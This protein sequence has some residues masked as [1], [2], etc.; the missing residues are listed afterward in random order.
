VKTYRVELTNDEVCAVIHHH[1]KKIVSGNFHLSVSKR[2]HDLTKRLETL[3]IPL[4]TTIDE[5]N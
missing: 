5:W 2:I 4:T 3:E 1:A